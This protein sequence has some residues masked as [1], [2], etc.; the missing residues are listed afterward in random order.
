MNDFSDRI[1]GHFHYCLWKAHED[2]DQLKDG[3]R[4]AELNTNF[5]PSLQ[6]DGYYGQEMFSSQWGLEKTP[7]L[8]GPIY[9]LNSL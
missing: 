4:A 7:K 2:E 8:K 9:G 3:S 5:I 1:W 6:M